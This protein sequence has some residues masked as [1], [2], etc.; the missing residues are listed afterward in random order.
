M[1]S[2]ERELIREGKI[3]DQAVLQFIKQ[4][5]KHFSATDLSRFLRLIMVFVFEDNVVSKYERETLYILCDSLK[6]SR[7]SIDRQIL[8]SKND[9]NLSNQVI[10]SERIVSSKQK[11]LARVGGFI[12]ILAIAISALGY[13][14]YQNAKNAF[15]DFDLQ[16]YI[17]ENPKLVFKKIYFSKYIIYGK[18]QGTNN[19]FEKLYIYLANGNA[20]FQF[21][22]TKL[23]LDEQ[24]TD[25]VTKTLVMTYS[26]E[27]PIEI[28]V[29]IPQ[30][31]FIQIDELEAAPI[32]EFEAASVAK[33]VAVPAGIAGGYVGAK[34]GSAIG[35]AIYRVPAVG[36]TAGGLAGG[37]IGSGAAATGAY[38]MTKNFLS[39]LRL[40]SNTLGEQDQLYGPTK[41]LIALE[42]MGGS[43]LSH[44][45]WDEKVKKYYQNELKS[46]LSSLFKSYGW[47]NIRIVY[48]S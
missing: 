25:F 42:L 16:L 27:M 34:V 17:E 6:I 4:N 12:G 48:K 10:Q 21:D 39:G 2:A 44:S 8:N 24:E 36:S 15:S 37:V 29:N 20:D 40:E 47:E 1:R 23:K 7:A 11:F 26:E 14:H 32:S 43:E 45:T 31:D 18:P 33:L 46:R 22:L 28:D 35:G 9:K 3:S 13:Y 41:H 38:I 5:L 19:K 30:K